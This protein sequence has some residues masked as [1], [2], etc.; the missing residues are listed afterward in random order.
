MTQVEKELAAEAALGLKA[1]L[2]LQHNMQEEKFTQQGSDARKTWKC[3]GCGRRLTAYVTATT[4]GVVVE[5]SASVK[6]CDPEA[7]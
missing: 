6:L 4:Y 3:A 1:A 7:T 2:S 5:G